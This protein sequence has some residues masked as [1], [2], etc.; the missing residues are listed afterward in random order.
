MRTRKTHVVRGGCLW[1]ALKRNIEQ[2]NCHGAN[3]NMDIFKNHEVEATEIRLTPG[4]S[5]K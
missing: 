2:N 1:K 4:V 5:S 3:V